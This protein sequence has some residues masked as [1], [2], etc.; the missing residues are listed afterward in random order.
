MYADSTV[1]DVARAREEGAV[2]DADLE[3]LWTAMHRARVKLNDERLGVRLD[4]DDLLSTSEELLDVIE[5]LRSGYDA[6]HAHLMQA[7]DLL[8]ELTGAAPLDQSRDGQQAWH[9]VSH[10]LLQRAARYLRSTEQHASS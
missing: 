9:T 4:H 7:C 1:Y 3:Q 5:R 8:G 10:D 2:Y 6:L